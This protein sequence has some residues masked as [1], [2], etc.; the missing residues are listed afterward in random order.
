MLPLI[1]VFLFHHFG[2]S[3]IRQN[4]G[5]RWKGVDWIIVGVFSCRTLVE[6]SV[7]VVGRRVPIE[8]TPLHGGGS[9]HCRLLDYGR[10]LDLPNSWE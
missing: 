7:V 4:G 6:G 10:A 8:D 5:K 2:F 3:K 9:F 1:L